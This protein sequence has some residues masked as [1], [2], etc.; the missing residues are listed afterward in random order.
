MAINTTPDLIASR[1]QQ[2]LSDRQEHVEALAAIDATLAKV[3]VVLN[4]KTAPHRA[5]VTSTPAKGRRRPR[6]RFSISGEESVLGL[7]KKQG[8][9]TTNEVKFHWKAEGRGGT[10]D[11]MLTKLVKEKKLKRTPLKDQ[12]GSRYTLGG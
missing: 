5:A 4:G 2:L 11:N 7:I 10:A 12:R 8:G 6:R 1:I 9:A 3:G